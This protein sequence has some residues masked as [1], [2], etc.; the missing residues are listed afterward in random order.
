[1]DHIEEDSK[2]VNKAKN[3]PETY[4]VVTEVTGAPSGDSPAL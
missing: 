2:T 3:L 1:M 4:T